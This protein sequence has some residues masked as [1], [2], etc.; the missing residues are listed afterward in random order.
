[1]KVEPVENNYLKKRTQQSTE[2]KLLKENKGEM[3]MNSL[4]VVKVAK[5]TFGGN[6]KAA[7][8]AKGWNRQELSR[9][10]N[11]SYN[12][13]T[14]WELGVNT[15]PVAELLKLSKVL[16][17]SVCELLNVKTSNQKFEVTVKGKA[18]D[19]FAARIQVA[20]LQKG[21]NKHQLANLLNVAVPSITSWEKGKTTPNIE[22]LMKISDVLEAP[23]E[24]LLEGKT[25]GSKYTK[26]GVTTS[27]LPNREEIIRMNTAFSKRLREHRLEHSLS[28]SRLA[29]AIGMTPMMVYKWE[30]GRAVPSSDSIQ[31][32]LNFF[33]MSLEDFLATSTDQ[34]AE[35]LEEAGIKEVETIEKEEILTLE[36]P[37]EIVEVDESLIEK[38]VKESVVKTNPAETEK[39]S[40]SLSQ[41]VEC[42]TSD[43]QLMITEAM[44]LLIQR[45]VSEATSLMR[46]SSNQMELSES[47]I[48]LIKKIRQLDEAE[49]AMLQ[50]YLDYLISKK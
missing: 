33:E 42:V 24:F 14:N 22:A 25:K 3:N 12:T 6:L 5:E 37:S 28:Q 10:L 50:S 19:T 43:A 44:N 13:I 15:P 27:S 39:F 35:R 20:R 41:I 32:L 45:V 17:I 26:K 48:E 46:N 36:M 29:K 8:M 49:E 7:R 38:P 1:M 2:K 40:E 11:S 16:N 9:K 21:L 30:T 18:T 31:K 23:L 47:E 4:K 34:V